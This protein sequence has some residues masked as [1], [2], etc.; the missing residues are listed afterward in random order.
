LTAIYTLAI[1]FVTLAAVLPT[2]GAKPLPQETQIKLLKAQRD[3]QSQQIEIIDLQRQLDQATAAIKEL[4]AQME[5]ECQA[6][7]KA[8][9]TDPGKLS[10]DL[11]QL[12]FVP[13]S[14]TQA[15]QPAGRVG[16]HLPSSS[17]SRALSSLTRVGGSGILADDSAAA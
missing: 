9:G 4:Q 2:P 8:T 14:A 13:K 15:H 3:I 5:A 16:V 6:A 10:C 17:G 7:A 1:A 12:A 11:E